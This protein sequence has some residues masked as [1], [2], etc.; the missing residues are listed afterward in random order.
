MRR[1]HV[2]TRD[3]N[4]ARQDRPGVGRPWRHHL[5]RH[6]K[7]ALVQDPL[8]PRLGAKGQAVADSAARTTFCMSMATVIG[9]T[10]PGTGV[11]ALATFET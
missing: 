4:A 2:P 11:I 5:R 3:E 6:R 9:P 8:E 10:P 7:R 1:D